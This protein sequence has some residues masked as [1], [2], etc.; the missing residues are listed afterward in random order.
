MPA[1]ENA[2]EELD[3]RVDR[4]RRSAAAAQRMSQVRERRLWAIAV[5]VSVLVGVVTWVLA[6]LTTSVAE[7]QVGGAAGLGTGVLVLLLAVPPLLTFGFGY[8]SQVRPLRVLTAALAT[9]VLTLLAV[10]AGSQIW[11]AG[12]GCL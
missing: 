11:W 10:W 8:I 7:C 12:H 9:F 4:P 2:S 5:A 3:Q 6:Q 1:A